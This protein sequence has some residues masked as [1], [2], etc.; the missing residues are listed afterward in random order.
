MKLKNLLPFLVFG[1][2]LM[3]FYQY[4]WFLIVFKNIPYA[5]F[6]LFLTKEIDKKSGA[7]IYYSSYISIALI[8]VSMVLLFTEAYPQDKLDGTLVIFYLVSSILWYSLSSVLQKSKRPILIFSCYGISLYFLIYSIMEMGFISHF[9]I[10]GVDLIDLAYIIVG[11]IFYF[12]LNSFYKE[13]DFK[14][15]ISK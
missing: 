11:L 10:M 6:L 2:L 13:S 1:L 12:T 4:Y 14:T 15:L 9:Y 7:L 8:I 5:F 3:L